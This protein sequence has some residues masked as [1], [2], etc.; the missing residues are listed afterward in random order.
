MP[1]ERQPSPALKALLDAKLDTLEKLEIAL[2]LRES[3]H[4][5]ESIED[6][7]RHLQVGAGALQ[8][9]VAD[10]ERAGVVKRDD[11]HVRLTLEG[12]DATLSEAASLYAE[13]RH[14]IMR[15]L[16]TI[17]MERIRRMAARSFADAFQLRKKKDDDNG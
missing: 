1:E 16:T 17:A 15:L 11:Q 13:N 4:G 5:S 14:Q 3:P 12:E 6:L 10:M 8:Q 2:A 7:A 9:V